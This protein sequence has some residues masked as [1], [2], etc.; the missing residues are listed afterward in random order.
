[1]SASVDPS[2][3]SAADDPLALVRAALARATAREASEATAMALATVDAGGRPSVRMVLLKG[4]DDRGFLFYTNYG[5]RKARDLAENV[6]AALCLHWPAAEE[7][8][9]VEGVVERV[10]A[11]ESDAYFATRPR[12]SRIAAWASEQ[13]API[14]SRAHL[15]ERVRDLEARFAG[16][17]VP[18]PPFWGGFRVVPDRIELWWGRPSR[19]HDRVAFVRDGAAFRVERLQP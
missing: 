19:L 7:Q 12:G 1:M 4:I 13:S 5:S 17:E 10:T 8:V 11:A 16:R 9:R 2:S 15:E 3:L 14:G 18:R 6:R